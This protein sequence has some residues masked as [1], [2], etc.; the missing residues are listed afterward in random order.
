M[1]RNDA[2]KAE[3]GSG[4]GPLPVD[5]IE[6]FAE[7]LKALSSPA[8]LRIV[9]LLADGELTVSQICEKTGLKQ[10]LVS[11][12]LRILRLNRIVMNRKEMPRSYYRLTE[13]NVATMLSCL[14]RCG[15][16]QSDARRG[17][18]E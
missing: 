7:I 11:Q 9:N 8:R 2:R 15:V 1:K 14:S 5:R 12:Q 16:R 18:D 6:R 4:S 13:K 17:N 3:R 10:S